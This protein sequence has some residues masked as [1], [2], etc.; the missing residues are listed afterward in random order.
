MR[1]R[2]LL[3]TASDP[4]KS[5][6]L[7][8]LSCLARTAGRDWREAMHTRI[9]ALGAAAVLAVV[10]QAP[11]SRGTVS[12][13]VTDPTGAVVSG[14]NVVLTHTQTGVRRSGTSNHARIFPFHGDRLGAYELK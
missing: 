5:I 14:A 7:A 2:I 10:A 3:D 12:G 8:V 9:W 6:A 4:P 13:S 11:T 1:L